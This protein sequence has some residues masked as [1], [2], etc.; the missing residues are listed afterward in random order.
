MV[1]GEAGWKMSVYGMAGFTCELRTP[2]RLPVARDPEWDY[3]R[4]NIM[5]LDTCLF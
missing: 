5:P 4:S 2:A 3:L 1:V